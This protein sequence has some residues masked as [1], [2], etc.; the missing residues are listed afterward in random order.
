MTRVRR[1]AERLV[2][3]LAANGW[4]VA[5]DEAL[6]GPPSDV[7]LR[8]EQLQ[9]ISGAPVPPVVG[10]FWRIVGSLD[11]VPTDAELPPGVPRGLIQLDP[12]QVFSLSYAWPEVDEWREEARDVHPEIAGPI[13]LPISADNLHKAGI[14]GAGP[15]GIW[16]PSESADPMVR[17]EPHDLRFTDYLRRAFENKGFVLASEPPVEPDAMAWIGALA[18]E[19]EPF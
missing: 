16:F 17:D 7:E 11:I 5:P 8:L 18:F 13:E 9:E 6:P 14:S 3:A 4:P 12:L 15:Y 10:A 1:N 2:T 19:L